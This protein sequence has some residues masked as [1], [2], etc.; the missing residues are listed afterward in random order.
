MAALDFLDFILQTTVKSL[1]ESQHLTSKPVARPR[2]TNL[3]DLS[4][5]YFLLAETNCWNTLLEWWFWNSLPPDKLVFVFSAG[6]TWSE[7]VVNLWL[8]TKAGKQR[9]WPK[10]AV[11]MVFFPLLFVLLYSVSPSP[12]VKILEQSQ[13]EPEPFTIPLDHCVLTPKLGDS[14]TKQFLEECEG[15]G[16]IEKTGRQSQRP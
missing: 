4:A 12:I 6:W 15:I 3:S 1:S 11:T 7:Q 14:G 5:Q 9:H 13:F 10:T 2:Q 16:K 8:E